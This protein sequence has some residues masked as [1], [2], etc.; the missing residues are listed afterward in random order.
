MLFIY[1]FVG[2]L[3]KKKPLVET[4][5]VND[6]LPYEK[7]IEISIVL[8]FTALHWNERLPIACYS[9]AAV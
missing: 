7:K 1:D 9:I 5:G 2:I 8:N 4:E 6:C 3:Q